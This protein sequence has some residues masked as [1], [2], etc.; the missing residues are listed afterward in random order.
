MMLA[1]PL[2]AARYRASG[3]VHW[4]NA[5]FPAFPRNVRWLG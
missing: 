4:P 5:E 2:A 1:A 3:L